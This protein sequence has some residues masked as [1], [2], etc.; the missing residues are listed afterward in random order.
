[1]S[2]PFVKVLLLIRY[3]AHFALPLG[4]KKGA[5]LTD[6]EEAVLNKKR[7]KKATKKYAERQK[8]AKV[9]QGLTDQFMT[10]EL[11]YIIQ[12]KVMIDMLYTINIFL[13]SCFGRHLL[14]A[15]AVRQVGRLRAGGQGA[16]VLPEEDQ[17]QEGQIN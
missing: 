3:E 7:S 1:M 11:I 15:R 8:D 6:A 13:R 4:R 5:K 10:G 14:P 16:G 9:E 17:G 2:R 12:L